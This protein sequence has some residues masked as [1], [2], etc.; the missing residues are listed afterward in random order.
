MK[1]KGEVSQENCLGY[2]IQF[3]NLDDHVAKICMKG[4]SQMDHC[5]SSNQACYQTVG[6][7]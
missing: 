4:K 6:K 1:T 2:Q 7:F 3:L 5:E